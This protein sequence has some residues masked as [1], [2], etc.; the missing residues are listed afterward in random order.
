MGR[1]NAYYLWKLDPGHA[2]TPILILRIRGVY[3]EPLQTDLGHELSFCKGKCNRS[4]ARGRRR[5]RS[6]LSQRD[7]VRSLVCCRHMARVH[8]LREELRQG[9]SELLY[10]RRPCCCVE[11]IGSALPLVESAVRV[12]Y[13]VRGDLKGTIISTAKR[14]GRQRSVL[15]A[16]LGDLMT[17]KG[18][19]PVSYP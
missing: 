14:R 6:L 8:A 15:I 17:T 2:S 12:H 4:V 9:Q 3:I 5:R 16:L 11:P 1:S 10:H 13:H 7:D 18:S 19:R